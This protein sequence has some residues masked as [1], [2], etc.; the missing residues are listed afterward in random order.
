[1][2]GSA[3]PSP[4]GKM[5][6]GGSMSKGC[7]RSSKKGCGGRAA[8]QATR[9]DD[10]LRRPDLRSE[11]MF[12][13]TDS[14][15]GVRISWPAIRTEPALWVEMSIL[16]TKRKTLLLIFRQSAVDASSG[17]EAFVVPPSRRKPFP[18]TGTMPELESNAIEQ[19][20]HKPRGGHYRG[21]RGRMK[22]FL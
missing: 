19:K 4:S 11:R 10:H 15:A 3:G 12:D 2:S 17:K 14:V 13:V 18:T 20:Q 5:R 8:G 22:Q 9:I 16:S 7:A 21:W 1:M 6:Q